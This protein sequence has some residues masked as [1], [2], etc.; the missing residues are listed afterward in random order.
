MVRCEGSGASLRVQLVSHD[1][2]MLKPFL[3][4]DE[5]ANHVPVE[6]NDNSRDHGWKR[7]E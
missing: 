3:L 4:L 2:L 5:L 7:I 6:R 1:C